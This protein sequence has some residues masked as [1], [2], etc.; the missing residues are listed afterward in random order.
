M[1]KSICQNFGIFLCQILP[2]LGANK[3]DLVTGKIVEFIRRIGLSI[4]EGKVEQESFL[5]GIQSIHGTLIYDSS[6]LLFPG[7]LLHEA[8]HLATVPSTQRA[9]SSFNFGGTGGDEMAA[10]AWS[11]AAS[12]FLQ[13]P[14]SV[15]FHEKGYRGDAKWLQSQFSQGIYIGLYML[16]W[17]GMTNSTEG[18]RYPL[19]DKWLCD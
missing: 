17:R 12:H 7:D 9:D 13:L 15:V 8:G 1:L 4:E 3:V 11:Y 10:I 2:N 6:K 18:K 19:M 14:L 16:E 5:P